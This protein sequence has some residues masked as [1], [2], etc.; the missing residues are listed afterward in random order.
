MQLFFSRTQALEHRGEPHYWVPRSQRK[1]AFSPPS[2]DALAESNV[3]PAAFRTAG[4][5]KPVTE[6]LSGPRN[7][8]FRRAVLQSAKADCILTGGRNAQATPF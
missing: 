4:S 8:P 1:K 6:E 3:S 2:S 7:A 5:S